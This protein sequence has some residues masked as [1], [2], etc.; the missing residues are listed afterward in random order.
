MTSSL[1]FKKKR[2]KRIWNNPT[3]EVCLASSGI[4][5]KENGTSGRTIYNTMIELA[6]LGFKNENKG[7]VCSSLD[8]YFERFF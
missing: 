1:F 6:K 3:A 4:A 2:T 8:F 5:E 7:T